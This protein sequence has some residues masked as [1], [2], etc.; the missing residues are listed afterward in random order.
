MDCFAK[1]QR[2]KLRELEAE[3]PFEDFKCPERLDELKCLGCCFNLPQCS[4]T[5]GLSCYEFV[6]YGMSLHD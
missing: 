1:E 3:V 2:R 4:D 5:F 6:L